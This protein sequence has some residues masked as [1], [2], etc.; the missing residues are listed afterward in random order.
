[1]TSRSRGAR[2]AGLP[3][4]RRLVRSDSGFN[5]CGLRHPIEFADDPDPLGRDLSQLK[6][7]RHA[8]EFGRQRGSAFGL[9]G[10][11]PT[12][13]TALWQYRKG[14]DIGYCGNT[15]K[16][17]SN[18]TATRPAWSKPF[19]GVRHLGRT[20]DARWVTLT[21]CGA[22][23]EATFWFRGCGL[24]PDHADFDTLAEAIAAAESYVA[25]V[26]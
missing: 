14:F 7:H 5:H 24:S 9:H 23:V 10:R 13:D 25:G 21:E 19:H 4:A 1:M 16:P 17:M 26:A 12:R 15:F 11:Q 18:T 20:T 22:M 2:A 8:L 6:R 3:L